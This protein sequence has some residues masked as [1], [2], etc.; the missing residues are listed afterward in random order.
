MNDQEIK[1]ALEDAAAPITL[2]ARF[3]KPSALVRQAVDR[4]Q[5]RSFFK[6]VEFALACVVLAGALGLVALRVN[7]PAPAPGGVE[8]PPVA[9][10]TPDR[11]VGKASDGTVEFEV[12]LHGEVN[13]SRR[14]VSVIRNRSQGPI[15]LRYD[16]DNLVRLNG[17]TVVR[18]CDP[19]PAFQ[20]GAGQSGAEEL[21][22]PAATV[23]N[24]TVA[25][26]AYAVPGQPVKSLT[27]SLG[28]AQNLTASDV[29]DRLKA[30]GLAVTG[31]DEATVKLFGATR[32]ENLTA[33]GKT[34]NVYSFADKAAAEQALKV[35]SD[36]QANTVSWVE[37]PQFIVKENLLIGIVSNDAWVTKQVIIA[38]DDGP[39]PITIKPF[40]QNAIE[41]ARRVDHTLN[42]EA[43][44][45]E[46][47]LDV[48]VKG[49]RILAPVWIVEAKDAAGNVTVLYFDAKS[50]KVITKLQPPGPIA[51]A[52]TPEAAVQRYFDLTS[53]GKYEEAWPLLH[54]IA[55]KPNPPTA[56]GLP[57]AHFLAQEGKTGPNL[58][59]ILDV[60]LPT[61]PIGTKDPH[62]MCFLRKATV[63]VELED[64]S[65]QTVELAEAAESTWGI[66]WSWN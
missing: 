35:A 19:L 24:P 43:H 4:P 58:K 45:I 63:R 26:L 53:A 60:K 12:T 65:Q 5:R 31:P 56:L 21:Q 57:L 16:C 7:T 3:R 32:V 29:A 41:L 52:A 36:P 27:A 55:Q 13:G 39:T 49:A 34:V 28:A 17:L 2:P 47:R 1:A 6:R 20:L 22:L 30:A 66:L 51:R 18:D 10:V 44:L 33:Q 40:I 8:T 54:P 64:G 37:E 38:L 59:A 23:Q 14:L 42:W 50:G 61:D 15:E 25:T 11:L 62:C 48:T 9:V 46:Q